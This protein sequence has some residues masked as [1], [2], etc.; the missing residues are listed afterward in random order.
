MGRI[1][2]FSTLHQATASRDAAGEAGAAAHWRSPLVRRRPMPGLVVVPWVRLGLA[3][4]VLAWFVQNVS[5]QTA[6][7]AVPGGGAV[8]L[9]LVGLA[10]L[11]ARVRGPSVALATCALPLLVHVRIDVYAISA[12]APLASMIAKMATAQTSDTDTVK[13]MTRATAGSP[14]G[15]PINTEP[16]MPIIS[17]VGAATTMT[18]SVESNRSSSGMR[19]FSPISAN[20]RNSRQPRYQSIE[21]AARGSR[22]DSGT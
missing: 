10:E 17:M 15:R 12:L 8:G 2:R 16:P 13:R 1:L 3:A 18:A 11:A 21:L 4:L 7:E 22:A 14:G 9:A 19:Y 6:R 20:S 5:F